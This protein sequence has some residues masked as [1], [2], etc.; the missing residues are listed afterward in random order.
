[1]T[2]LSSAELMEFDCA[3]C[4]KRRLWKFM[5]PDCSGINPALDIHNLLIL[6]CI[7]CCRCQLSKK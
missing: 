7:R 6:V 5:C 1:M 3:R 4:K 2:R